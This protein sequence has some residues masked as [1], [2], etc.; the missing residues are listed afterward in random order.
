[1]AGV[2]LRC[3]ALPLVHMAEGDAAF[4]QIVGGH[5]DCDIVPLQDANAVFTHFAGGMGKDFMS[6]FQFNTEHGVRQNFYHFAGEFECF[7]FCHLLTFV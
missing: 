7:F 4:C 3:Q 2:T 5:F 6:V 1:M